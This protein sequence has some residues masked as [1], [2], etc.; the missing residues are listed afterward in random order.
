M[1]LI[2]TRAKDSTYVLNAKFGEINSKVMSVPKTI[3][4]MTD[5]KKY[6]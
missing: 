2:A 1:K 3:D 5:L 4:D 6:I